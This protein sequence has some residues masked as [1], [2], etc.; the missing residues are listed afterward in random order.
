MDAPFRGTT[1]GRSLPGYR[2][3][4]T[5]GKPTDLEQASNRHRTHHRP[6]DGPTRKQ[7]PEPR[8]RIKQQPRT[9][10]RPSRLPAQGKDK[11]PTTVPR[12]CPGHR[13]HEPGQIT[14]PIR[15]PTPIMQHHERH[16]A[17]RAAHHWGMDHQGHTCGQFIRKPLRSTL[18]GYR[19]AAYH[20][21]ISRSRTPGARHSAAY[22]ES[23]GPPGGTA[24][25]YFPFNIGPPPIFFSAKTPE[26]IFIFFPCT[27][28]V[29]TLTF[30]F[31]WP[32]NGISQKD[33]K[34][35]SARIPPEDHSGG[36]SLG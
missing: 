12:S 34:C 24:K 27:C 15:T 26:S 17:P 8:P 20:R 30:L 5:A 11:L 22:T 36:I 13:R 19:T 10:P 29:Y 1:C 31:F 9:T 3:R 23:H 2:S 4:C 28:K 32:Y 25:K 6:A 33:K 7:K 16:K 35:I 14:V 21:A 18:T